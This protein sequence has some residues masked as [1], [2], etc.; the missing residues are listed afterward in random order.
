MEA[1]GCFSAIKITHRFHTLFSER[2]YLPSNLVLVF[3]A[4]LGSDDFGHLGIIELSVDQPFHRPVRP[5]ARLQHVSHPDRLGTLLVEPILLCHKRAA[6][7]R[8]RRVERPAR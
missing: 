1:Y 3:P 7:K 2:L 8:H 6:T 4:M 5:S